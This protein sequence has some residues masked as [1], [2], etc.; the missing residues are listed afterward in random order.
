MLIL[1]VGSEAVGFG[2][3]ADAALRQQGVQSEHAATGREALDCMQLHEYDLVLTDLRLPDMPGDEVV[4]MARGAGLAT[5]VIIVGYAATPGIRIRALDMGADD[6]IN[7]P[8][9]VEELSARIRAIVRRRQGHARS[10]LTLGCVELSLDRR[11]LRVRGQK[12]P[13]SRREFAVMELLFLKQG[14]ILDKATLVNHL[15][16]GSDEPDI[17]SIDVIMCRLRKKLAR[18][19]VP[20]LINT[21]WGCGYTLQE[22]LEIEQTAPEALQLVA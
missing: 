1:R 18:A 3:I 19:G 20:T 11:D 8:C 22:A 4:R 12:L 16:R 2:N 21:I 10:T 5:P 6:F 15:Y 13:L 7:A 14:T 17:K 9:E